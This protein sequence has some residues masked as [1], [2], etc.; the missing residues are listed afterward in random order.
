MGPEFLGRIARGSAAGGIAVALAFAAAGRFRWGLGVAAGDLWAI[1]NLYVVRFVV[2]RLLRPAAE[3]QQPGG[4][5]A[6]ISGLTLKF[7]LLYGAGYLMLVSGW[8]R[9]EGL[10]IGFV[11]PFA[12]CFVDALRQFAAERR[13]AVT[14]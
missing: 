2:V 14:R 8:F 13:Q 5:W 12:A 11:V 4:T 6:L 9:T 1:A 10:V 3:R 7:P